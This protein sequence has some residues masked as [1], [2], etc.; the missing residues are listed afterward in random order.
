MDSRNGLSSADASSVTPGGHAHYNW[1]FTT[2]GV[3]RLYFQARGVK[4]DESEPRV[5]AETPFTFHVLPLRP[6]E[7]W[8]ATNW[9]CECATNLIA[10]GADPD[11]DHAPNSFEYVFGTN[12][13]VL[14]SRTWVQPSIVTLHGTGHRHSK[15]QSDNRTKQGGLCWNPASGFMVT[16]RF[17]LELE[18][19]NGTAYGALTFERAFPATDAWCEVFAADNLTAPA[20]EPVTIVHSQESGPVSERLTFRDHLP[21][22]GR[23][24]RYFQFRVVFPYPAF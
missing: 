23:M 11:R 24:S 2:S 19:T 6:F 1:G 5:S 4:A 14:D 15:G 20:W 9:P 17:L 3:Y 7:N 13:R 21:V 12:P 16:M 22:N 10:A 8:V 18:A